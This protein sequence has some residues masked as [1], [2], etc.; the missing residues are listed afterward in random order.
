METT[1]SS[2]EALPRLLFGRHQGYD[3]REQWLTKGLLALAQTEHA[4]A[5]A[6]LFAF[7]DASDR[8]GIGPGMVVAL[9]YWLRATGLMVEQTGGK[10]G[11]ALP[12]L[13]P[14]GAVLAQHDP[15]L[16]RSGSRWLLHAHL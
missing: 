15:Y 13:T 3:L 9:R 8:F 16:Q 12:E 2:T 14:L 6:R 5:R 1:T 11:R 7:P 10:Q 4:T